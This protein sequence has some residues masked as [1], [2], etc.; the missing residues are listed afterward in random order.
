MKLPPPDGISTGI[1]ETIGNIKIGFLAYTY[2]TNAFLNNNYL[3]K[4]EKWWVNLFQEQELHNKVYRSLYN[5]CVFSLFRRASNKISRHILHREVFCPVYERTEKSICFDRKIQKDIFSLRKSGAEYIV[6]CLHEGGQYNSRPRKRTG[7][8]VNKMIRYGVDAVICNHE[9]VI[10][11]YEK[12]DLNKVKVFSLGNFTG[13]AGVQSEPYNKMADYS[14]LFNLYLVTYNGKVNIEK[15]TFTIAKSISISDGRIQTV[16]L[17]NL[18]N[19][20]TD[21]AEKQRLIEDN[22]K[23]Y[24]MFSNSNK[25]EIEIKL[26]YLL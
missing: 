22:L 19:N 12:T 9:H 21:A 15:C 16:L 6:M 13:L 24:N 2:G 25:D 10:H 11:H 23:I 4:N 26:E 5:S 17:Y 14:V 18:I 20:C 8:T 3:N 1:I 7:K